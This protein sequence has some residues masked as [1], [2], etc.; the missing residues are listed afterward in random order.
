MRNVYNTHMTEVAVSTRISRETKA[1]V[2]AL[3][4]EERLDRS[5]ALRKLLHLGADEY[6]RRKALEALAAGKASFGEAAE[7]A[8]LTLWEFRELVKERKIHWVAGAVVEDV[9]KGLGG[10]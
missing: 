9:R 6:R 2:E 8:G 5:A 1:L 4:R 7:I 10:R 3:M